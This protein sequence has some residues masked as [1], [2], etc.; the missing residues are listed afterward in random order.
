M[1][2]RIFLLTGAAE[3][4]VLSRFLTRPGMEIAVQAVSTADDLAYAASA[5]STARTRLVAFS[6]NVMVP[7]EVLKICTNGAFNFHPGPPEV[8]GVHTGA[9]A[10]YEGLDTF[11]VTAHLMTERPDAGPIFAVERFPVTPDI[12][13]ETLEIET[14]TALARL[15]MTMAP[16]L[17]N[18]DYIFTP[19]ALERWSKRLRTFKQ[20]DRLRCINDNLDAEELTRRRRAFAGDLIEESGVQND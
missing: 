16:Q 3:I 18:L 8:P 9:F 20:Y 12:N 13:R 15:F 7:P 4:P 14:Y 5:R 11:G 6:T 1:V 19:L 2:D 10:L 17:A